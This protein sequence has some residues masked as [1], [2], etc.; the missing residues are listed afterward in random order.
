M[1]P[2]KAFGPFCESAHHCSSKFYHSCSG[3]QNFAQIVDYF[4]DI[5][6]RLT[7][8]SHKQEPLVLLQEIERV[9]CSD[10]GSATNGGPL[11]RPLVDVSC[12]LLHNWFNSFCR[13]VRM[14]PSKSIVFFRP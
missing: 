14:H 8:Y 4:S 2:C 10:P 11:R 5:G 1:K 7:Y 12:K 13:N 3:A 9:Y 6:T